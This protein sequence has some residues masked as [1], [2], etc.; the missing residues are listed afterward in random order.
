MPNLYEKRRTNRVP[1]AFKVKVESSRGTMHGLGRDL[2]E[3]GVGVHLQKLPPVGSPVELSFRLP[4]SNQDITVT[5][6]VMYQ[7]RGQPGTGDDWVGVRFLRMDATSQQL[8]RKFVKARFDPTNPGL[9]Q[10]PP[11]PRRG[12]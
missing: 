11:L 2:S 3:G 10:P 4:G 12:R 7:E 5:G 1:I 9:A 6:E 8:I